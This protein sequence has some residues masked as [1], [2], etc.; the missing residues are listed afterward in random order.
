MVSWMFVASLLATSGSVIRNADRIDPSSSGSSHCRF[1]ASLAYFASTS[2][3]PVSGAA[4][5]IAS[6]AVRDLPVIS[7]IRAYSR[8]LKPAPS[9]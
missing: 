6:E 5:F 4:Q 3:F 1:C 8:L 9:L 7:A 2:I